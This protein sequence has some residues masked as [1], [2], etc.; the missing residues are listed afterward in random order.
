MQVFV[1]RMLR[2][3]SRELHS[4][5]VG[6]YTSR[7]QAKFVGKCE[8]MWRG[9]KYEYVVEEFDINASLPQ[10]QWDYYHGLHTEY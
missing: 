10:E 9:G 8:E 1:T 6:V 2:Y 4:Y 7:E 3:G 5:I